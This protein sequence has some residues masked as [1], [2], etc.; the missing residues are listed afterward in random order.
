MS[1]SNEAIVSLLRALIGHAFDWNSIELGYDKTSN[2]L[3]TIVL[4][5]VT[6]KQT[7][8]PYKRGSKFSSV[9]LHLKNGR[10][11]V[12]EGEQPPELRKLTFSLCR[13]FNDRG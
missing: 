2:K 1:K 13:Y 12:V 8:V 3:T 11:T 10:V 9:T 4:G 6:C 5:D 7:V